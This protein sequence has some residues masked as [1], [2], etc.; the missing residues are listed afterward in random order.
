MYV[1]NGI[2]LGCSLSYRLIPLNS[3]RTL[4]VNSINWCRILAQIVYVVF[5]VVVLLLTSA[6]FKNASALAQIVFGVVVVVVVVVLL[7]DSSRSHACMP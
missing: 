7:I 4:K 2:P 5:V 1:T 6:L 3:V